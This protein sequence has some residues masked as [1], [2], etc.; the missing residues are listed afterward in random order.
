MSSGVKLQQASSW[1][2]F[3][4]SRVGT[5]T[6]LALAV[7]LVR[8][9]R[10]TGTKLM[11]SNIVEF[12]MGPKFG[13]EEIRRR[14]QHRGKSEEEGRREGARRRPQ[15]R[16]ELCSESASSRG[17][18]GQV[19]PPACKVTD[20]DSTET[21]LHSELGS[22]RGSAGQA[23]PPACKLTSVESPETLTHCRLNRRGHSWSKRASSR[24]SAGQ[25]GC[26]SIPHAWWHTA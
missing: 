24:G 19:L 26:L 21:L 16:G 18:A 8:R 5:C 25:V 17:P 22:S 1:N 6:A 2:M 4:V 23:L 3:E 15:R 20:I 13:G 7:A 12:C 10:R 9:P 11:P 14:S